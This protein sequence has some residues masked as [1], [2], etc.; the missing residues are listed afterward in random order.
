MM[1]FPTH[2]HSHETH[3]PPHHHSVIGNLR[4]LGVWSP[5]LQTERTVLVYLPPSYAHGQRRYPAL[6]MQDGQNLFDRATSYGGE[7]WQVDETLETLSREGLEVIAVG[8]HHGGEA[9]LAEYNPFPGRWAGRGELYLQFVTDT[10]KPIIDHDFR[11]LADR[12]HTGLFGSSMGGLISLY[13]F[14][15]RPEVFGLLGAMSPSLWISHG[16]IFDFI[17]LAPFNPGRI[18]L[19]NGTRE[20][21]ARPMRDLL[22]EKGY[23]PRT[24]LRYIAEKGGRHTE[25]AWARRFP[26]AVRFLLKK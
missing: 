15:R 17:R 2:W 19:D 11:T 3:H 6:Y 12:A 4:S 21:S 24:Q 26:G 18:Y 20:P 16:A 5:Q 14:F 7:E 13:G 22:R 8:L 25:S 23:T 1:A 10:L 9:R